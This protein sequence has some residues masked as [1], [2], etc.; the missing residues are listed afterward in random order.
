MQTIHTLTEL[1]TQVAA[2][3]RSGERVAFVPTMGN[4]HRGH[5][6]LV[7]RA[8]ELAPRTIA[9]IFVNPLQFGPMRITPAIRGHWM[10]TAASCKR[11]D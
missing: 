9:S 10:R 6:C 4:L 7:E 1:R 2:W 5:I 3:R 8:R 11:L